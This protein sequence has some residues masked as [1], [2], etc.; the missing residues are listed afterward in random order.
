MS[1]TPLFDSVGTTYQQ[2]RIAHWDAVARKRDSW[3]GLGGAYHKRLEQVYRFLVSPGQRVL[4][5]GCGTGNLLA[6]LRPARGVGVDFS[7]ETIRRARAKHPDLEFICADAHDLA[8]VQGPFDFVIFSDTINDVWDAQ[9]ALEQICQL[10]V[11][12]ARIIFNFYSRL[13]QLPLSLAQKLNLAAPMLPQNWLTPSD[14]RGMLNLAGFEAIRGWQEILWPLPLGGFANKF[15]VRLWPFNEF[16]LANFIIA[17]P[18]PPSPLPAG[19]GRRGKGQSR[20]PTVSVIIPAR[21]ESG[22]IKAIFERTPKMGRAMELIFVEGHSRDDTYATI[23]REMAAHLGTLRRA[24]G[25]ASSRLLRQTGIGKADAVRLGFAEAKGDVLMILDADLTVPPED[26]PRFYQALRGGK[27]EF[28]NGVRLVYPMEK[29]AMQGLNFLGNKFFSLAFSWLLGQPIKDT[30]C[31]TKVL[32]KKD[33]ELIAA[34]RS[35][36]GDFDP[37]GDYDLIFGAAK[38]NLKIV[39]L[40]IRYRERTYGSTNISRWKHGILLLRMVIFAARRIKF[41]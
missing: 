24:Q 41:V 25:G 32:W 35:Y 33:Y 40:P 14:L 36:F 5:I 23:E 19:E 38:L 34:N 22:N 31:G 37:F 15:L 13:W 39:D 21:N 6:A 28:I 2:T 11:P 9:G 16:A 17:R 26:L 1:N 4:E 20:E 27:G 18:S 3:R 12:S 30:L 10:C 7:T 8:A 29:E